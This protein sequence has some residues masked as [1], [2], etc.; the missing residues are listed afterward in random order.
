MC[1]VT[2]IPVKGGFILTSSR[3]ERVIRPTLKP[4][5]YKH[6][7]QS[8]IYPKDE[9]AGGTW[10]ASDQNRVACMLNGAFDNHISKDFYSK[11]RG[12]IL[13]ESFAYRIDDFVQ[14][15][16]LSEI[17]PFTLLLIE[18]GETIY[19][20]ELIWDGKSKHLNI[21]DNRIPKIW[22]SATLYSKE[23]RTQ[24]Q[25]WFNNWLVRH[26]YAE[27]RNIINFHT[28]KHTDNSSNNV[29]MK[30]KNGLQTLSISQIRLTED[31]S[32]F[33]YYDLQDKSTTEFDIKEA[34]CTPDSR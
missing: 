12:T 32:K 16:N 22:S 13:L 15:I 21:S 30:R 26:A 10:I 24:R 28:V 27:D 29:M 1:T 2:Y 5:V 20:T 4:L 14:S 25:E 31:S 7:P 19:I 34:I 3:D 17:E 33:L 18:F 23:E 9:I 6:V 11:S 8:I